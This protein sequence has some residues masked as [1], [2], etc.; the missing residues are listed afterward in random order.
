M[1]SRATARERITMAAGDKLTTRSGS[2]SLNGRLAIEHPPQPPFR[3]LRTF[4]TAGEVIFALAS[5]LTHQDFQWSA[6]HEPRLS[7][8]SPSVSHLVNAR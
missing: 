8:T 4:D 7:P 3:L 1:T 5:T 2:H 6:K